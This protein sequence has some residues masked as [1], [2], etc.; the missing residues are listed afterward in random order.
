M[1]VQYFGDISGKLYPHQS[2]YGLSRF[3]NE[4]TEVS[5]LEY[6]Y[7]KDDLGSIFNET[8]HIKECLGDKLPVIEEFI[9][10]E[11]ILETV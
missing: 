4:P 3:G 5:Y 7:T 6:Y 10:D 1:S 9:N 11:Q 2:S 8:E